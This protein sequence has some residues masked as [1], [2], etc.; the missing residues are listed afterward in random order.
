VAKLLM[1]WLAHRRVL[2]RDFSVFAESL[3]Q[4]LKRSVDEVARRCLDRRATPLRI[5]D[6]GKRGESCV[7][8]IV[9]F[10]RS[11]ANDRILTNSAT[12]FLNGV[13]RRGVVLRRGESA[14]RYLESPKISKEDLVAELIRR[15]GLCRE[16]VKRGIGFERRDNC[17]ARVDDVAA[18]QQ[19]LDAQPRSTARR[20]WEPWRTNRPNR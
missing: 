7:A 15:E 18:A 17:L 9:R 14:D 11:R 3:T 4:R 1:S 5:F 8:E 10:R 2:I 12:K 20:R 6:T 13:D 19:I 16:L